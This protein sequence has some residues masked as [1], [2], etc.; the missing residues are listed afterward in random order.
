MAYSKKIIIFSS[1]SLLVALLLVLLIVVPLLKNIYDIFDSILETKR[2]LA[3][4]ENEA[5]KA[6][7]FNND[8][9]NLQIT[10]EKIEQCLV[11][12][13]API[14]LIKFFEDTAK[15]VGLLID[16]SPASV[17]KMSRDS[18]ESIGFSV[19]LIGDFSS[20]M[21]FLEKVENGHYFIETT[22][23]SA[24][25]ITQKDISPRRYQEFLI[26][27]ILTLIDFKAYTK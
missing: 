18:W 8:Y 11:N 10:S 2:D 17:L 25:S 22:K 12:K 13:S 27:Q 9:N 26:G 3:S 24:K 20:S 7:L 6:E 21:K 1:V 16:I 4:F 5:S 19:E 23:F 15:D 14:E